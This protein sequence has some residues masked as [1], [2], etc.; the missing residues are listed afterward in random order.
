M[1]TGD[2]AM[3]AGTASSE[4]SKVVWGKGNE[5]KLEGWV[6]HGVYRFWVGGMRRWLVGNVKKKVVDK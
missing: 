2:T 4:T 1:A 6:H 5:I 3:T